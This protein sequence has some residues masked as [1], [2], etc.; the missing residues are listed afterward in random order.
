MQRRGVC[1]VNCSDCHH[2]ISLTNDQQR[3]GLGVLPDLSPQTVPGPIC[4]IYVC[5]YFICMYVIVTKNQSDRIGGMLMMMQQHPHSHWQTLLSQFWIIMVLLQN[6]SKSA[7][8]SFNDLLVLSLTQKYKLFFTV[9]HLIRF[10]HWLFKLSFFLSEL[11]R[12]EDGKKIKAS[13][14][15]WD[16][17]EFQCG[18]S[19]YCSKW[20]HLGD[21]YADTQLADQPW[22]M[23]LHHSATKNAKWPTSISL[24]IYGFVDCLRVRFSV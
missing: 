9:E 18:I 5:M 2:P 17:T 10:L 4:R 7:E 24:S 19:W 14:K 15:I 11:W 20:S 23:S 1:Q 16:I 3:L 6:L 12:Q 21:Q 22:D 13:L 8:Q